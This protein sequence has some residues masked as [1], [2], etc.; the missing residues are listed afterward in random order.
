PLVQFLG[1]RGFAIRTQP[2]D[3]Y[4]GGLA[5]FCS[6][7]SEFVGKRLASQAVCRGFDSLRPL[8]I[9][10][11]PSITSSARPNGVGGTSDGEQARRLRHLSDWF[12]GPILWFG[13]RAGA[14]AR[15]ERSEARERHFSRARLPQDFAALNTG[16]SLTRRRPEVRIRIPRRLACRTMPRGDPRAPR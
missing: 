5:L 13:D 7:L 14:V 15:V 11:D 3:A 9:L 16:Y 4:R 6:Y 1:I 12:D 8:Q 2:I 10:A